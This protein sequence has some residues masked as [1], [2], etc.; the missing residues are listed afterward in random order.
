MQIVTRVLL[1]LML[2]SMGQLQLSA[3]SDEA[4]NEAINLFNDAVAQYTRLK[5]T[6][7][8]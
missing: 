7:L 1:V 2:F 6:L 4:Q 8:P 3:Q 5:I